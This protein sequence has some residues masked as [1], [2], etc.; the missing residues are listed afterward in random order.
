LASRPAGPPPLNASLQQISDGIK[1]ATTKLG[2]I[3]EL[4]GSVVNSAQG[5]IQNLNKIAQSLT[6]AETDVHAHE[7]K[8]VEIVGAITNQFAGIEQQLKEIKLTLA[9]SQPIIPLP[10]KLAELIQST[11]TQLDDFIR[12]LIDVS[13]RLPPGYEEIASNVA[14]TKDAAQVLKTQLK[15]VAHNLE[16]SAHS[17]TAMSDSM[18]DMVIGLKTIADKM[19]GG[20][21]PPGGPPTDSSGNSHGLPK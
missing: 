7:S 14:H 16:D 12:I 4:R 5:V 19:G 21:P 17:S 1:L 2:E 18:L 6:G 20:P 11:A 8:L 15:L 9:S 10:E 3:S 13:N